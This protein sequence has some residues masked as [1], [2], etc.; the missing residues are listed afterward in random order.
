MI[1]SSLSSGETRL[2]L[3]AVPAGT[4]PAVIMTDGDATE[5]TEQRRDLHVEDVGE[6]A[7]ELPSLQEDLAAVL[8]A[9]GA[10][11][12]HVDFGVGSGTSDVPRHHL[13][14]VHNP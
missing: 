7:L 8:Q 13:N 3:V 1:I 12:D 4:D 5:R 2:N 10:V 11:H 9:F 6:A 14:V